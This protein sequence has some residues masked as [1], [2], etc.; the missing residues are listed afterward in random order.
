MRVALAEI[1]DDGAATVDSLLAYASSRF[2][3]AFA[4]VLETAAV[5][6]NEEQPENGGATIVKADDE[7]AVLPPVSGGSGELDLLRGC[8][9]RRMQH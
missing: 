7:V 9:M 5:W 1:A 6:V 2:G 3:G 8:F 4:A